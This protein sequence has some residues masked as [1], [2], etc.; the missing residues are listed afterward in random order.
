VA[1]IARALGLDSIRVLGHSMGA[2]GALHLADRHPAL[3]RAAIA[4][5]WDDAVTGGPDLA[6]TPGYQTW[7]NAF[8][9]WLERLKTLNHEERMAAGLTQLPPG[10]PLLPEAEYVAWLDNAAHLDLELVRHGATLWS[11]VA[12]D[13]RAAAEALRRSR[14]PV[15]VMKSDHFPTP[16]ER[17]VR[18]EP[19]GQP[20]VRVVRFEHTGHLIHREAF[21]PFIALVREF[22][23]DT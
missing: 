3:V 14:C 2:G 11:R 4:E 5:G 19:S 1:A 7:Y 13:T 12:D 6:Q 22:F 10:A 16:G 9:S 20:N 15:L 18:D 8:V 17:R 23:R 21:E